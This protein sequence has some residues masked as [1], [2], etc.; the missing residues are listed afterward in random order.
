[1]VLFLRKNQQIDDNTKPPARVGRKAYRVS[2]RQPGRR[3][4][5]RIF[6][7]GFFLS[8]RCRQLDHPFKE[9]V[10]VRKR[11]MGATMFCPKC[12]AKIGLHLYKCM[13]TIHVAQGMT[14]CVCG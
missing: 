12:K 8:A 14:C 10:I 3:T 4:I 9:E 2:T 11:E 5:Q 1:M 13:A 7:P 6:S